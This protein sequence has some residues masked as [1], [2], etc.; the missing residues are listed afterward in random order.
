VESQ[1]KPG[2]PFSLRLVCEL[3]VEHSLQSESQAK[4]EMN[5]MKHSLRK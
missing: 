4:E 5:A 2:I 3:E 1:L